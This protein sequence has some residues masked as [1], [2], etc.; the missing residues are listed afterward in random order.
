VERCAEL[1]L[2]P[3]SAF[4]SF[5]HTPSRCEAIKA[6]TV[7]AVAHRKCKFTQDFAYTGVEAIPTLRHCWSVASGVEVLAFQGSITNQYFFFAR[8]R[9]DR[10]GNLRL[11][12]GV[13]TN[14]TDSVQM[15]LDGTGSAF[16]GAV[17]LL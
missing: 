2:F 13:G 17:M 12:R 5:I 15:G 1:F 11:A 10:F 16:Q 8:L 7:I 6:G 3:T 9:I 14:G 4:R